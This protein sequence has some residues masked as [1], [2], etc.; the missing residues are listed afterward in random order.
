MR[1]VGHRVLV[2]PGGPVE[3][4]KLSVDYVERD[5]TGVEQWHTTTLHGR[6]RRFVR[7]GG[8][9][10]AVLE[11]SD[12]ENQ[13][14]AQRQSRVPFDLPNVELELAEVIAQFRGHDAGS[15]RTLDRMAARVGLPGE[16]LQ[17][18]PQDQAPPDH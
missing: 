8:V 7:Q 12:Y 6:L 11:L 9:Y 3:R 17:P 2:R 14:L 13:Y 15:C 10:Q 5:R 16:H 1:G 4:V 18:V